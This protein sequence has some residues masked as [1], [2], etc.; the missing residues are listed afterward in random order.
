[1]Y[2]IQIGD[3]FYESGDDIDYNYLCVTEREKAK[4]FTKLK[5]AIKLVKTLSLYC[6]DSITI[7]NLED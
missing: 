4:H 1:M 3:C 2:I 6:S 5:E 7:I